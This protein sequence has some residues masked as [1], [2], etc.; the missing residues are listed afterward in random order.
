MFLG[1]FGVAFAAKRWVPRASLATLFVAAQFLDLLWPLLVF[2]G[3]E[4][5]RIAPG[6]TTVNPLDFVHY[7]WSHSLLMALLWGGLFGGVYWLWRRR[8]RESLVAGALVPSHWLLDL[9]VHRP[10]LPLAPGLPHL[11]GFTAW[12]SFA[13]S[14]ALE[15]VALGVGVWLY[16]RAT[17]PGG[18][19]PV[20]LIAL[21]GLLVA[22]YAGSLFGPAPPNPETVAGSALAMWL[23]VGLAALAD[24]PRTGLSRPAS[25]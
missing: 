24:R 10:D 5:L 3:I 23:F 25:A 14:I 12:N 4:R 19:R 20:W 22:I 16:L 11:V 1:H 17:G 13:L 2:A 9:I 15:L 7:P 18:Y 8:A 6:I 21:V